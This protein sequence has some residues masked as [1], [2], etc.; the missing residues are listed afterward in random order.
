MKIYLAAVVIALGATI[1]LVNACLLHE[2]SIR[3][4]PANIFHP[5]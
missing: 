3:A 5:R 2:S 4:V 1:V